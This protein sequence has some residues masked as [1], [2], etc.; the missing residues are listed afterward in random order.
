[1]TG[2]MIQHF[3]QINPIEW[4]YL[5]DSKITWGECRKQYQQPPWCSYPDAV[6]PMGCWSL[7]GHKVTGE[8]YCKNCDLY[9]GKK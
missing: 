3:H 7:I 2:L 8:D 4:L 6:D 5:I 9:G 1:M